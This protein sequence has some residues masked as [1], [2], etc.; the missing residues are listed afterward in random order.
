MISWGFITVIWVTVFVIVMT[1]FMA[2]VERAE[3]PPCRP[4]GSERCG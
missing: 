2:I 3:A 4:V 1:L